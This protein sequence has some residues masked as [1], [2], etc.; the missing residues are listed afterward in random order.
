PHAF[1]THRQLLGLEGI[2][3]H[4]AVALVAATDPSLFTMQQMAGDVETGGDIA[5]GA[6]VFDRRHVPQW[7]H[8]MDVAVELDAP[9]VTDAIMRQLDAS[10]R[11][12]G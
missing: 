3:L 11:K 12:G 1:R 8:N 7:R 5:T 4:D 6:T 2:H 10:A 9:K